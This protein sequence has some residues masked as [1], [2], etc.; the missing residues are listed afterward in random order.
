MY[1]EA[2]EAGEGE[3]NGLVDDDGFVW[4]VE[5]PGWVVG[6]RDREL[7]VAC[8]LC[9]GEHQVRAVLGWIAPEECPRTSAG[10][11]HFELQVKPGL[12]AEVR[13]AVEAEERA[14][15]EVSTWVRR[16]QAGEL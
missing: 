15:A 10:F 14:Q 4:G 9:G 6:V 12:E 13:A 2:G 11:P 8:P 16:K 7:V 3:D 5:D 1:A